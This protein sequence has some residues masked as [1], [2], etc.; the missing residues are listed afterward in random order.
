VPLGSLN[1]NLL[2]QKEEME[3]SEVHVLHRPGPTPKAFLAYRTGGITFSCE[4]SWDQNPLRFTGVRLRYYRPQFDK[5]P[6]K[7]NSR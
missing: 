1:Q 4:R 6:W 2:S 3:Y 7:T 5:Y